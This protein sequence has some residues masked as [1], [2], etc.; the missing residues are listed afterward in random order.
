MGAGPS[1]AWDTRDSLS[2]PT[3]GIFADTKFTF[4]E[5]GIGSQVRFQRLAIDLR[6][7]RT[8]WLD[9][10]L[11][12][13]FV[14]QTVWGEVPFQRLPQLGGASL[15]RGWFGGQLRERM[16]IAIEAEYRVPLTPRWAVVA[17]G[18]IGRVANGIEH[19]DVRELRG[20]GGGGVRFSVDKRDRVNVRLD[21]AYGDSFFPYLQFREAF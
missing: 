4:F 18:S 14:S 10:V 9:H 2:W 20:A 15:F 5:P 6:L 1:L 12:L 11:A 19:F 8:L 16:L 7:F 21:L 13:R 17:F 3:Q